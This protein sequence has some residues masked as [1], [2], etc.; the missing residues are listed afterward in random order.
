MISVIIPVCDEATNLEAVHRDLCAMA[1]AHA[2]DAEW[3]VVDD[4][5]SDGTWAV[6]EKLSRDDDR[7][8]ALK[9]R[10][11]FGKSAAIAAGAEEAR[12]ET[13]CL[14]DGDGQDLPQELPALLSIHAKSG[15]LVTG[16]R[17]RRADPLTKRLASR[18]FNLMVN[19]F[20]GMRLHD[21]NCGLK[22]L[23]RAFFKE[24]HLHG[25]MHRF[26]PMLARYRGFSLDEC[27]V[28]HRPRTGGKTKYG[29]RRFI[30]GFLDLLVLSMLYGHRARP[31]HLMGLLGLLTL[32]P[33]AGVLIYLAGTWGRQFLDSFPYEPIAQ[34]PL[35]F[36]GIAALLFGT[37][38]LTMGALA[39]L[40]V[41]NRARGEAAY[42]IDQRLPGDGTQP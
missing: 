14:L 2:L 38:L 35:T 25:D 16:W 23:P 32:L 12:G 20:T 10:R 3:I 29:A 24:V 40:A 33:G 7:L 22:V 39:A 37:Q 36:Y 6:I 27:K 42:A 5:S 11:N 34:R 4:G 18:A 28:E 19:A 41:G 9:L 8:R 15:G 1:D 17:H 21:H 30:T 31:Q 13:I 26:L